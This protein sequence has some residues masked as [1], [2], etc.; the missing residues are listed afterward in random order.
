MFSSIQAFCWH[1]FIQWKADDNGGEEW[2]KHVN[3]EKEVDS[4]GKG[5]EGYIWGKDLGDKKDVRTF[6][7]WEKS[8]TVEDEIESTEETV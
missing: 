4:D 7:V 8:P 5:S 6:E 3:V 2:L 1:L